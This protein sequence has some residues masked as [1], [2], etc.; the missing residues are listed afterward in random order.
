MFGEQDENNKAL[1]AVP[2]E[3]IQFGVTFVTQDGCEFDNLRFR[4]WR[5]AADYAEREVKERR[6]VGFRIFKEAAV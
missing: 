3:M 4:K 5:D 6:A 1:G 2:P